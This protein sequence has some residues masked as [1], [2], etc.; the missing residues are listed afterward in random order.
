[1]SSTFQVKQSAAKILATLMT[2][3]MP[4]T[5]WNS[6]DEVHVNIFKMFTG[7]SSQQLETIFTLSNRM[8]MEETPTE[9]GCR[10]VGWAVDRRRLWRDRPM[11]STHGRWL[12]TVHR[13]RQPP[14]TRRPLAH[15]SRCESTTDWHVDRSE[16]ASDERP[17][18][19]RPYWTPS[20]L[21]A[22]VQCIVT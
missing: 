2:S 19:G 14:S 15:V 21:P 3:A 18:C 4:F 9:T 10:C 13:R 7:K 20:T 17:A 5:S 22:V 12:D 1:M 16:P 11:S 8:G 6:L